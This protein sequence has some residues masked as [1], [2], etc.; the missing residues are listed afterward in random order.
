M[1]SEIKVTQSL[2]K[3][4]VEPN[5]WV[6]DAEK[7][8]LGRLATKAAVL[9]RGKH[10]PEF[11]P[12]V[13]CGDFVIIINAEKVKVEGKRFTKKEYFHHTGYPGG[14]K[15]KSYQELIL[16]NPEFIISHAVKGMLP[17]NKLGRKIYKKLKV[18]TGNTHPH[19]AQKPEFYIN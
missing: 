8:T 19:A 7:Q 18:Y 3:E 16:K 15:I 1:L 9:L 12:H 14:V 2:R 4:D 11:T 10:K 17:K 13:D 6:L 5:W